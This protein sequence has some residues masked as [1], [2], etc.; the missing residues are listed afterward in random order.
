LHDFLV[1]SDA[2]LLFCHSYD[3]LRIACTK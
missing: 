2:E 1:N 3:G